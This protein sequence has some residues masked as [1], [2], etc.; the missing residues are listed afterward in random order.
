[1]LYLGHPDAAYDLEPD[2]Q[3]RLLAME[4]A[5]TRKAKADGPTGGAVADPALAAAIA[6]M[7]R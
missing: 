4:W 3:A 1:M 2:A 5:P 7:Q 6:R